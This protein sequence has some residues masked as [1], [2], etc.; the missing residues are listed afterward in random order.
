MTRPR[1]S[2]GRRH[3]AA[4]LIR[5]RRCGACPNHS[6][7][8]SRCQVSFPRFFNFP[9][10][11]ENVNRHLRLAAPRP[12]FS[13][14]WRR[15]EPKILRKIF[16][17]KP[18]AGRAH[19]ARLLHAV[20]AAGARAV[21]PHPA[22]FG[23]AAERQTKEDEAHEH[24]QPVHHHQSLAQTAATG[25]QRSAGGSAPGPPRPTSP[26]PANLLPSGR[27]TARELASNTLEPFKSPAVN[28]R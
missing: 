28:G 5:R 22:A 24:E 8:A 27:Q 3:T 7:A 4:G 9:I 13:S 15:R 25:Q 17:M 2:R 26:P 1:T 23:A 11:G 19:R 6:R 16:S 14:R 20:A 21:V 18:P 12:A 10:G